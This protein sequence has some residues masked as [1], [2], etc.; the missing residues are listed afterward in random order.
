M[1]IFDKISKSDT[2][3]IKDYYSKNINYISKYDE[4]PNF[5]SSEF[6][7][8]LFTG[9]TKGRTFCYCLKYNYSIV[10]LYYIEEINK[11]HYDSA[12]L[13]YSIDKDY[14]NQGITSKILKENIPQFL[15][16][17]KVKK[18]K[19]IIDKN[20]Q[21]SIC[22]LK[23]LDFLFFGPIPNFFRINQTMKDCY[24]AYSNFS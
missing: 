10:G 2:N 6:F 18:L 3:L 16:D 24:L 4:V 11:L 5:E 7:E 20:N 8:G 12:L 14:A 1:F 21:S 17:A 15:N 22:V 23:K 9:M 13:S 19:C